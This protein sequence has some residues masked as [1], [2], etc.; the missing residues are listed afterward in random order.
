MKA[1]VYN[2]SGKETWEETPKPVI[3][4]PTDAIVRI[5]KTSISDTDQHII[6]G[7][8][9]NIPDGR[10]LGHEGIG[11]IEDIGSSVMNFKIG[12]H[13]LISSITSCGKC[14]FCKQAM[15]SFCV[16]GGWVL[17]NTIDGTQ[18]EYVRIPF[19]DHSLYHIPANSDEEAL[20]MLSDILPTGFECGVLNGKVKPGDTIAIVG[21]GPIGIAV[22]LTAKLFSS[23]KI[24]IIDRDNERLKI[25]KAYGAIHINNSADEN[26]TEKIMNL[27]NGKGVDVAIE[28]IGVRATFKLCKAIVRDGGHIANIGVPGKRVLLHIDDLLLRK[29]TIS[30][31]LV[32]TV[33]I[34]MLFKN[35]QSHKLDA[36]KL[37]TH[38]YKLNHIIDA[39][40]AIG[41][42]EMEKVL[43]VILTN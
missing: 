28:T 40:D 30:T 38:H 4:E 12:K 32:D 24:I 18:A 43:K 10:I 22:L 41:S 27:T 3:M 21:A 39:Y 31:C 26:A 23:A 36:K 7:D 35:V 33:S 13:V 14:V 19:A 42:A 25:A 5:L 9:P 34:P 20:V 8:F 6:R 11:V 17:G 15:Y 1:L 2:V 16:N 37:I 29:V